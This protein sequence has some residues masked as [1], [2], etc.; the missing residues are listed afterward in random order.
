MN[1]FRNSWSDQTC[2]FIFIQYW[3]LGSL[4]QKKKSIYRFTKAMGIYLDE[5]MSSLNYR[6]ALGNW[7][8]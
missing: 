3:L 2:L 5:D 8:E 1:K 6:Q 7:T 4:S